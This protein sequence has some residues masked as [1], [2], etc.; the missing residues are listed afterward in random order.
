[1]IKINY[2]ILSFYQYLWTKTS[3]SVRTASISSSPYYSI[4]RKGILSNFVL[5]SSPVQ[6][7]AVAGGRNCDI[8]WIKVDRSMPHTHN[9]IRLW[10]TGGILDLRPHQLAHSWGCICPTQSNGTKQCCRL[11]EARE[12]LIQKSIKWKGKRIR[13]KT[14]REI[15]K[16][17]KTQI[18]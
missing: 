16:E 6:D 8:R 1:M 13:V 7:S 4:L 14:G 17:I 10:P 12:D 2:L 18:E 15:E 11:E 9:R 5:F 3:N